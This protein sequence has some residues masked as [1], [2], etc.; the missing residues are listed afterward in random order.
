MIFTHV[1]WVWF[2]EEPE[3]KDSDSGSDALDYSGELP[4]SEE[5]DEDD[6]DDDVD[7]EE[8]SG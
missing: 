2:T 7:E 5:D 8:L 6:E 4:S 3:E 1:V